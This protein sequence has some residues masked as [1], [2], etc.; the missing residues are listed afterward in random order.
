MQIARRFSRFTDSSECNFSDFSASVS[1]RISNRRMLL[2]PTSRT[3][4]HLGG[5]FHS[6]SKPTIPPPFKDIQPE[7]LNTSLTL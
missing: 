7:L 6:L 5:S 2:L 1:V 3:V 4:A